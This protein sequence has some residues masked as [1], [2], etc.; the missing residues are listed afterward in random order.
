MK[1]VTE[2]SKLTGISVRTLHHYD[3]IGLLKPTQ[4]T[5]AGY[6]LYDD[7]ALQKLQTILLFRELQFPL[8]E[9]A[10]ILNVPHFDSQL[11]LEEQIHL[12]ELRREHLDQLIAHA[13][14]IQQTGGISMNFSAFDKTKMEQYASEAK[15][16]WGNTDAYREFEDKTKGHHQEQFDAAANGLMDIFARMGTI[17]D[18]SPDSTEAQQ[19]VAELK[20]FITSHY[21]TCTNQILRGLGQMYTADD[22]MSKN[23][24]AA[25]GSGTAVFAQKAIDIFCN[26]AE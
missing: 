9:I 7:T 8:K 14:Y 10:Q 17:R 19:L 18:T 4:V 11:A 24:D 5:Q 13:R 25:G 12:L 6:R 26:A 3:S 21:Y 20:Q 2:V 16:R 1:T 15:A 22:R 23:I